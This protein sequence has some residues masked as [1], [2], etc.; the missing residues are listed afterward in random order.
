MRHIGRRSLAAAAAGAV[1][2]MWATA[3][4]GAAPRPG[5]ARHRGGAKRGAA[6]KEFR[7]MWLATV[8]NR[9]WPSRPG[10]PAERQRAELLAFLDTAVERRLNAVVFQA[11][12]TAD[13]LWPSPYEP[14]SQYLTGVQGRD[15]GWDPLGTAVAEAHARDLELHAWFNPYR[16]ANHTDPS[17]LADGHPARVH[18]DWVLPYGGKLYYNPGL[19]QVR[20]FVQDAMLDAVRRYDIDAVHFDDYFY[21][22]PVAGQSFA[23]D[24]TYAAHGAGFPDKAAWRRDNIDRLVRE[25]SES[26]R[27]IDKDV[28]FG[29][30]PFGVWRN[31]AIDPLGS[32]TRAGVQTYDH[33]HADTR[34]WVK[35]R[36][37][38]YVVPQ[39]Y[40]HIGFATADYATLVPWWDDVARGTNVD[41]Y[42]GEALYKAGDPAQPA[43]WQDPAELSRHLALAAE[44]PRVRG[45]V[46]FSAKEVVTDRIGAM[47]R[48]VADHYPTPVRPPG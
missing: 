6:G 9:D 47:A 48:V 3:G 31:A 41:L 26:I 22:Y 4:A 33:L 11:R 24:D 27:E 1:A 17:R 36:W 16:V 34:K 42:V 39:L 10:L 38:D 40:W 21:P 18:P 29:I 13:A 7:G 12:P 28:R 23:D 37:I 32:D 2:S 15:P 44:H 19:P 35:E 25:M 46:F 45:H 30:S 20:R 5:R 43:A 14:W 8:A